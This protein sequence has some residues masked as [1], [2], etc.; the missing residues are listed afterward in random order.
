M[1]I[2]GYLLPNG[3][4]WIFITIYY[5]GQLVDELAHVFL[6]ISALP[7]QNICMGSPSLPCTP[8]SWRPQ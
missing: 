5:I 7:E 2:N 3:K 4:K 8:E 1:V 6:I